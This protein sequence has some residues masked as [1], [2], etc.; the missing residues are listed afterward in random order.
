M[1][2]CILLCVLNIVTHIIGAGNLRASAVIGLYNDYS[3]Y[4]TKDTPLTSE[5]FYDVRSETF[6]GKRAP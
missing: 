4:Y 3:F 2:E 5:I 1:K 6:G